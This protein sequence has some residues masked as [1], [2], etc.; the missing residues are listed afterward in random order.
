MHFRKLLVMGFLSTSLVVNL[1]NSCVK[2]EEV[3]NREETHV[4]N[5]GT[6]VDDCLA[7]LRLESE[8]NE[9]KEIDKE[10]KNS[11]VEVPKNIG[12]P[13]VDEYCNIRKEASETSEPI[14]KLYKYGVVE[15]LDDETYENFTK[16]KI[17]EI[18]GYINKDYLYTGKEAK[19]YISNNISEYQ[20]G[21]TLK[22][23]VFAVAG[24][25]SKNLAKK[26]VENF[27]EKV[28]VN[29]AATVYKTK[30]IKSSQKNKYK[31]TKVA[32]LKKKN[33][34]Y[35]YKD[36]DSSS[37]RMDVAVSTEEL[38]VLKHGKEFTKIVTRNN[39]TGYI[40]S[41]DLKFIPKK[42]SLSN[43][44]TTVNKD[45]K[46][47][48]IREGETWCEIKVG[49]KRGFI[50]REELS[51][52]HKTDK[53]SKALD[54]INY[55]EVIN[56]EKE[57]KKYIKTEAGYINKNLLSVSVVQDLSKL[58]ILPEVEEDKELDKN[59]NYDVGG[60]ATGKAKK[61]IEYALQY[62]GNPY[63]WG[64]NSL[65]NGVDCS[66]FVREVY[67]HFGYSLPRV[68]CDQANTYK[69]ISIEDVRPADLVFYHNGYKI[70]HVALYIGDNKVLH[71]SNPRDGIKISDWTYRK[72]YKVVRLLKEEEGDNKDEGKKN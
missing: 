61:I 32:I 31:I 70:S 42:V 50:E 45:S 43:I 56:V 57:G 40:K 28:V 65:I 8:S 48:L 22:E 38:K 26:E 72:P 33:S 60:E 4:Y 49:N 39:V 16:V 34:A 52:T 18:I 63:V 36:A 37:T 25:K 46:I 13:N 54:V 68:A 2:A 12:T 7:Y 51:I 35:V 71:A 24:Y 58:E 19:K 27:N 30:S 14:A 6:Q 21:V 44:E 69:E 64:G 47:K 59:I 15:V 67:K 1:G 5:S 11:E 62:L 17:G 23:G 10:V 41:K 29:D 66:G 20:E 53:K 3:D 9:I 55:G